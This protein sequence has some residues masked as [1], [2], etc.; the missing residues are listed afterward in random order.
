MH[1]W[2][3]LGLDFIALSETRFS[4]WYTMIRIYRLMETKILIFILINF[5]LILAATMQNKIFDTPVSSR[6][7]QQ[8]CRIHFLFYKKKKYLC[9]INIQ[10]IFLCEQVIFMKKYFFINIFF[11]RFFRD[12]LLSCKIVKWDGHKRRSGPHTSAYKAPT[13]RICC[14]E[15]LR[16][17]YH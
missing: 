15:I 2:D 14:N 11:S 3:A 5:F 16:Y 1:V 4:R 13:R 17:T 12:I 8:C 9:E 7:Q 6:H 10:F